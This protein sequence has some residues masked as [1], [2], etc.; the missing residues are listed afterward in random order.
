[1]GRITCLARPSVRPFFCPSV[2]GRQTLKKLLHIWQCLLTGG[3]SSAVAHGLTTNYVLHI[4][5]PII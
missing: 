5:R 3:V 4:V 1:M 2:T